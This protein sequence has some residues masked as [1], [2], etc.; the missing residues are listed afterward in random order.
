MADLTVHVVDGSDFVDVYDPRQGSSQTGTK[1]AFVAGLMDNGGNA[2]DV[3][4]RAQMVVAAR[5]PRFTP[6]SPRSPLCVLVGYRNEGIAEDSHTV[7]VRL[8]F[9][10]LRVDAAA[11]PGGD[12]TPWTVEDDSYIQQTT[13]QIHPKTGE[14]LKVYWK[15]PK[16]SSQARDD[17]LT[18]NYPDPVRRVVL[19]AVLPMKTA[20]RVRALRRCVN[21]RKWSGMPR[22]HW[23]CSRVRLQRIVQQRGQREK[24]ANIAV[25]LDGRE[26]VSWLQFGL[27]RDRTD[28]K[29]KADP[30]LVKKVAKV[31][32]L[33]GILQP[34]GILVAGFYPLADYRNIIGVDDVDNI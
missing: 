19:T 2:A 1:I 15:N 17:V 8:L 18:M 14:P 30:D 4:V 13:T 27:F 7:R 22:G 16:N 25:E 29:Y 33:N 9:S 5:Y 12:L 23:R 28:G 31:E 20:L 21:E 6:Y 24:F 3:L 26:E 32:Y 34:N 11:L 10:T